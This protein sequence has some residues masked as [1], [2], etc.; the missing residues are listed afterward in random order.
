MTIFLTY[1]NCE[2]NLLFENNVGDIGFLVKFA[3]DKRRTLDQNAFPI[4]ALSADEEQ[5]T[6]RVKLDRFVSS[7]I[8]PATSSDTRVMFEINTLRNRHI[9]FEGVTNDRNCC[10]VNY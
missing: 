9:T 10:I 3:F 1:F 4:I 5:I 7:T 8:S 2:A 6:L